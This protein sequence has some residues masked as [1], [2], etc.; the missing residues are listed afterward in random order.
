MHG[1]TTKLILQVMSCTVADA[2]SHQ[3]DDHTT[4][5]RVFIRHIDDFFDCLNVKCKLEGIKKRKPRREAYTSS[6]DERFTV[7]MLYSLS[8]LRKRQS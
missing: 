7:H 3:D 2:L 6:R 1:K 4:E 5:T 8:T